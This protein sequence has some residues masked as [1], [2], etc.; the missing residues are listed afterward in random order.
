MDATDLEG[1]NFFTTDGTDMWILRYFCMEPTCRLE[2][3]Q[4]GEKE[5]FGMGGLTAERF[6]KIKMP[7]IEG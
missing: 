1:Y 5:D 6:H 2:N 4:T 7:K 3:L